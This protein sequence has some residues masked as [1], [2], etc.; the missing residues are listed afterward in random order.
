MTTGPV[1]A[2]SGW[3]ALREPADAE[4]RATDLVELVRGCLP[5]DRPLEIRD[6]GCG[7]GSMARWLGPQLPGPQ[8]WVLYDRDV[9]LLTL[10]HDNPPDAAYD[11]SPVSVE[12]RCRDI[13]RLSQEELAGASLITASALLDM[14]TEE[15][16]QRFVAT[17]ARA[18][19]A[20]LITLTVVGR[21]ELTPGDPLDQRVTAA[22]NAHQ[23]R[24]RGGASRLGPDAVD[25]AVEA[26]TGLGLDVVVRPSPWRLGPRQRQLTREWFTGWLA[27]A[28]EHD[29]ELGRVTTAY[30][31]RRLDLI[32]AGR[33][34]VTVQHR[35][36]LA[37]P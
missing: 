17:C 16:L 32:D 15:E 9:E 21:V 1:R 23:R 14:M 35:D 24:P 19:C 28:C 7:T 12:T 4:S 22:F 30:A 3:L 11:G 25:A 8:H 34:L 37:R 5:A 29:P 20:V 33:L 2:S 10:V 18:G 27:A 6:L 31:R 26:F 13:T 36:L